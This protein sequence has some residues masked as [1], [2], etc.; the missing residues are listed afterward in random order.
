MQFTIKLDDKPNLATALSENPDL[1][2]QVIATFVQLMEESFD[3]TKGIAWANLPPLLH[4]ELDFQTLVT[5]ILRGSLDCKQLNPD[6]FDA[7]GVEV[8]PLAILS[9]RKDYIDGGT[10]YY[11]WRNHFGLPSDTKPIEAIEPTIRKLLRYAK[12][13]N[14]GTLQRH[15]EANQIATYRGLG[16]EQVKK[17]PYYPALR[18]QRDTFGDLHVGKFYDD[19]GFFDCGTN[20]KDYCLACNRYDMRQVANYKLCLAC[21]AGYKEELQ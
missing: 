18:Y 13:I 19:V 9:P 16:D 10:R 17:L 21:N 5:G 8:H 2:K 4:D 1:A 20:D 15:L 14:V 7:L 11:D 6:V 12:V 3:H